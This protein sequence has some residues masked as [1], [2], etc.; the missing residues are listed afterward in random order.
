MISDHLHL[1]SKG[2]RLT[3]TFLACDGGL[4][5][6]QKLNVSSSK[7]MVISLCRIE[8]LFH[9]GC[10]IFIF[11]VMKPCVK[12]ITMTLLWARIRLKLPASRLVTQP[13]IQGADQ[14]YYQS[15]A[16]MAFVRGIHRWPVNSPH[17][18]QVTQKMF[19]FDDV[20][21]RKC[22]KHRWKSSRND[23]RYTCLYFNSPNT[24]IHCSQNIRSHG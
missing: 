13:F 16:S 23:I 9:V 6:G 19:P 17:K 22:G 8:L 7:F 5:Q 14:I 21:M 11:C 20:I 3:D 4:H 24:R 1:I 10:Y 12:N 2:T 15:S 18:G